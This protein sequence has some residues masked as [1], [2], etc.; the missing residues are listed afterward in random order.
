MAKKP[1]NASFPPPLRL[2]TEKEFEIARQQSS[3]GN[4]VRRKAQD[5]P[6]WALWSLHRRLVTFAQLYETCD[7]QDQR[8]AVASSILAV[9]D[10]LMGRG[11]APASLG[12]MMRVVAALGERENGSLDLL[13]C[14][15]AKSGRPKSTLADQNRAGVLAA[16]ASFWLELHPDDD[17]KQMQKLSD[18]A[19]TMKGRWFGKIEAANLKTA[20]DLAMQ[21]AKDHPTVMEAIRFQSE[22]IEPARQKFGDSAIWTVL[23]RFL[24]D[25]SPMYEAALK[26]EKT[27]PISPSE[28]D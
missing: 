28:D 16:L 14:E 27:R 7:L 24:N 1:G 17:R 13:F 3:L 5:G 9:H 10:Y 12:P 2:P 25:M 26:I 6:E 4:Y 22:V 15:R 18:A 8:D 21:E 11:F 20:R 19:R 23:L